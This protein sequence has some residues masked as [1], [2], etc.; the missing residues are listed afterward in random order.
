M[1]HTF[2]TQELEGVATFWRIHRNDGV[3]LGFTSH[4]RDLWFDGIMHRAAPGMVPSAIRRTSALS[5]DSADVNGALGH[6]SISAADLASGRFDNA[7]VRIG[8]VDW[9]TLD[10]ATLY[11]GSIGSVSTQSDTFSAELR[12]AKAELEADFIPRTSPTCRAQFCGKGCTLSAL[13]FTHEALLTGIDF[14]ANRV[15]FDALD[16]SLFADGQ[17]RWIDGPHV[18]LKMLVIAADADGL[19]V[20]TP[21]NAELSL[22]SRAFLLEGCDHTLATCADRF[23]NAMNFQGE[24]YLP[25]NDL[26]ARYPSS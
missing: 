22:G 23:G 11:N 5:S 14:D 25:G 26:L 7:Q 24:P 16:P 6:N 2:F 13:R 19:T 9:E 3:T 20:D 10:H 8:A 4:N 21:L 17:I 12:S 15:Q 1:S 18:G